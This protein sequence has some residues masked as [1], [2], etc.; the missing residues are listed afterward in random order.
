MNARFRSVAAGTATLVTGALLFAGSAVAAP[1]TPAP[2]PHAGA[3]AGA[4]ALSTRP[5]HLEQ[6]GLSAVSADA[7]ND[8]WAVG[9]FDGDS[10][11]GP[12]I[13]HWDGTSWKIVA[14]QGKAGVGFLTGVSAESPSD[15]WAVGLESTFV[16]SVIEHWD[17]SRWVRVANP[18]P[19]AFSNALNAVDADSPTDAWAVGSYNNQGVALTEHWDGSS[20]TQ[21]PSANPGISSNVLSGV[22]AISP[23]DAWA[24]GTFIDDFGVTNTMIEHWDGTEWHRVASPDPGGSAGTFL[25]SVSADSA[26][27]AW[28]AGYYVAEGTVRTLTEHWDGTSWTVVS[29]PVIGPKATLLLGVSVVSP[30]D[31]W[32]VGTYNHR[33][34]IEHW[35]GTGWIPALHPNP[36]GA[37]NTA[38]VSVSADSGTDAWAVGTFDFS[39][40]S[41][42]EHWDGHRWTRSGLQ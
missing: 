4:G 38:L 36:G 30:A 2:P 29:T 18:N 13:R 15:V 19:G 27:D 8:A 14:N 7:P 11:Q 25:T 31:A 16:K 3:G 37:R 22:T 35:N 12:R 10:R 5:Q 33:A 24:V 20:W 23:T 40:R 21:V 41:V 1:R 17:G 34:V 28:A 32:V 39:A 9:S 6:S 42:I 26:T